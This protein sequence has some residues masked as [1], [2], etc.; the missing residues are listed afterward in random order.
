MKEILKTT[1]CQNRRHY[2]CKWEGKNKNTGD[3]WENTWEPTTSLEQCN[4]SITA[5]HKKFPEWRSQDNNEEYLAWVN[6]AVDEGD[7]EGDQE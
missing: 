7:Q 1:K 3:E 4:A 2:L 5:F 6:E